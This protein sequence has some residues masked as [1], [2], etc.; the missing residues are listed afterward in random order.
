MF[1]LPKEIA[2]TIIAAAIAAFI[3]LVGLIIT[4]ESKISE[5][6]QAWIDALRADIATIITQ[7]HAVS[8]AWDEAASSSD[9]AKWLDVQA[10]VVS[11]N[12]A[13]VRIKLRLNPREKSSIALLEALKEHEKLYDAAREP[14]GSVPDFKA[15]FTVTDKI[16]KATQVVLKEEWERVKRGERFYRTSARLAGISVA[17]ALVLLLM[18]ALEALRSS[19]HRGDDYLVVERSDYYVDKQGGAASQQ[20]YDHDIVRFVLAHDGHKIY[21]ECDLSTLDK[22]DPNASCGLRP[23]R[24]YEC[25]VGRD[26]V[27]KTSM[28]LSDLTCR[29][30]DGRRVYVYVNKEE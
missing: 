21:A 2:G 3:S 25:V 4:K 29:D 27:T 7:S 22:L 17:A 24:N 13:W 12:E 1:G 23:L 11:L 30:S 19:G 28:P 8:G 5:F 20:S 9:T 14:G 15:L 6:R 16:S 18:S 26:D 10:H